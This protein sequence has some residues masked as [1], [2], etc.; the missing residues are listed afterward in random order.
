MRLAITHK[1]EAGRTRTL[2]VQILAAD[3]PVPTTNIAGATVTVK[4]IADARRARQVQSGVLLYDATSDSFAA[5]ATPFGLLP[6]RVII[7]A[8]LRWHHQLREKRITQTTAKFNKGMDLLYFG[9]GGAYALYKD[10]GLSEALRTQALY[11]YT[12]GPNDTRNA[13]EYIAK[14]GRSAAPTPVSWLSWVTINR[15]AGTF[16]KTNLADYR[17]L[18]TAGI[19]GTPAEEGTNL[20]VASSWL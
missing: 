5:F 6:E 15:T 3:A 20:L 10:A 16:A 18:A 12:Q 1:Q 17:S 2:S 13:D 9:L 8:F 4:D 11:A 7:P 14:A 19:Q